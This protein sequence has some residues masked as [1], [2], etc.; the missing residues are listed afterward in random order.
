MKISEPLMSGSKFLVASKPIP[1]ATY[2][3][4]DK[5]GTWYTPKEVPPEKPD[6]KP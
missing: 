2:V 6:E 3:H 5:T 4:L 1:P